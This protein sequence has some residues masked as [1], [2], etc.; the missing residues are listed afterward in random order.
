[1]DKWKKKEL[2]TRVVNEMISIYYKAKA[3]DGNCKEAEELKDYA[4]VR[5]M[6]C[7]F[8]ETKTFC[9]QCKVHCYR[10]EMREK[11]RAVMR[12]SGPRM[13]LRNPMLAIRH[14]LCTLEDKIAKFRLP[15]PVKVMWILLGLAGLGLGFVGAVLPLLPA[16]PFLLLAAFSF[17]KGSDRLH[18]WFVG[19]SLYKDNLEDWV[20]H[21]GM[22][23]AA[24]IRVMAL[25]T[26]AVVFGF[27]MMGRVPWAQAILA[28]VWAGHVLYFVRGIK[29]LPEKAG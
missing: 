25:I 1:M 17:G 6:L 14:G 28:V 21:K 16:F 26:G 18:T 22:T 15:A 29:T 5:T 20:R 13:L 27:C 2:E 3:G 8:T 19:T 10:P 7:P 4:R 9:S 11:I 24:K 12:F 23:K